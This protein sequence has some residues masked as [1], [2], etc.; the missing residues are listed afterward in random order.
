MI[1]LSSYA[2]ASGR[3]I[4]TAR[5][6]AIVV[7]PHT[8]ERLDMFENWEM[9]AGSIM[10]A[11]MMSYSTAV[12]PMTGMLRIEFARTENQ[13]RTGAFEAVQLVLTAAQLHE[14]AQS[15]LQMA[16]RIDQQPP[17]SRQ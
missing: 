10:L 14:F 3:A 6:S 16:A 11:P 9:E 2:P 7:F 4:A 5:P 12:G 17:G 15:L 1:E 8:N 13:L